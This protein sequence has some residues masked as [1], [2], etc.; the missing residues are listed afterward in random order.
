[1]ET[2]LKI[3]VA[4][5]EDAKNLV[6]IYRY[7]VENTAVSYEYMTPT[8]E[9]FQG[10][11]EKTLKNY[12]YLVAEKDGKIIGYAYAGQ[13]QIRKAYSWNAEM[14]VYLASDSKGMGVGPKLYTLLE[15]I[16]KAQGV[17]KAVALVTRPNKE[18]PTYHYNSRDFHEKMGYRLTG[19]LECSGYK[20]GRWYDTL[21]LEKRLNEA[22]EEMEEVRTF[23]E[24]RGNFAL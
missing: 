8:V 17:A 5:A 6:D 20:F 3:R 2:K 23:E 16:L 7:Y 15:E 9:E 19:C 13:F 10:R 14:T 11:I 1:M 24:V 21:L 4:R 12:P 18:D 22:R